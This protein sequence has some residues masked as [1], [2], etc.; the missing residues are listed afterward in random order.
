MPKQSWD[1]TNSHVDMGILPRDNRSCLR[2]QREAAICHRAVRMSKTIDIETTIPSFYHTLR[3]DDESKVRMKW[4]REWW[5]RYAE[6]FR[7]TS[8][9]AV[10]EEL[11]RGSSP[12]RD[13]RIALVKA[14]EL[15]PITDEIHEI[16]EKY[17]QEL[18][19]PNDPAGDALHL[20]VASFYGIDYLLTWNCKHL[21][22]IR[23]IDH[24]RKVNGDLGLLTPELTTPLNFLGGEE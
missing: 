8:S 22:N 15:L 18:V 19:M 11:Q 7:L 24:I 23:K 3:S 12:K 6:V 2:E 20:A 5:D 14:V 9:V 21:A 4:T 17:I 10:I 1:R 16:A 13:D